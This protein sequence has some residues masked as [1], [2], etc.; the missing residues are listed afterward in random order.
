MP[1]YKRLNQATVSAFKGRLEKAINLSKAK[2]Y[3]TS[4]PVTGENDPALGMNAPTMTLEYCKMGQRVGCKEQQMVQLF[5]NTI[6]EKPSARNLLNFL[7]FDPRARFLYK[8]IN[9]GTVSGFKERLE[10]AL[11]LPKNEI[12]SLP[13]RP[14]AFEQ[15]DSDQSMNAP[16]VVEYYKKGKNIGPKERGM[17][18]EFIK[19]TGKFP[20][21]QN[22]WKFFQEEESEIFYK[23]FH[24]DTVK[25]FKNRIDKELGLDVKKK[26]TL[27]SIV[28]GYRLE[29]PTLSLSE[30][31][32]YCQNKIPQIANKLNRTKGSVTAHLIKLFQRTGKIGRQFPSEPNLERTVSKKMKTIVQ[33]L[34]PEEATKARWEEQML[35]HQETARDNSSMSNLVNQQKPSG[36]LSLSDAYKTFALF[37]QI[38]PSESKTTSIGNIDASLE[39]SFR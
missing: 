22:L 35:R 6:R 27:P 9:P 13:R 11:D 2:A 17:I 29:H 4:R 36:P 3:F 20:S 5:I 1:S 34:S 21:S 12:V 25:G 33:S 18:Q 15:N 24:I 30:L 14:E 19:S 31:R 8:N 38:N 7:T 32:A 39:N 23:N 28:E 26:K 16:T 37:S 10:K